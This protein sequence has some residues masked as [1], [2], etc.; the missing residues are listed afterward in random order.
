METKKAWEFPTFAHP[1]SQAF[2]L[3]PYKDKQRSQPTPSDYIDNIDWY[4]AVIEI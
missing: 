2:A 3:P 1:C 4:I